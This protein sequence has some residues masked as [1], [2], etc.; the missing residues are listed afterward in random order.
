VTLE[1]E[2]FTLQN[3]AGRDPLAALAKIPSTAL[4]VDPPVRSAEASDRDLDPATRALVHSVR[5]GILPDEGMV[6]FERV[7]DGQTPSVV[8]VSPVELGALSD[9]ASQLTAS[10]PTLGIEFE[11]PAL[12]NEYIEPT[13]DDERTMVEFWKQLLGISAVGVRDSFFDLGGHSLIA[14]RLFSM[15][16]SAWGV[17]L[18]VGTLLEAPTVV[19]LIERVVAARDH[20]TA[21]TMPSAHDAASPF[22]GGWSSL[23]TMRKSGSR[24][25]IFCVAGKGGNPMNLRHLAARLGEDQPFYG[26]QHRGVDGVLP[27]HESIESMALACIADVRQVQPR[28]PYVLGGFSAG[29]LVAFEMARS[30]RNAGED[31][32]LLFMLDTWDPAYV[33][34]QQK[35]RLATHLKLLKLRGPMYLLEKCAELQRRAVRRVARRWQGGVSSGDSPSDQF[36]ELTPQQATVQAWTQMEQRY[37][38]RPDASSGVLYRPYRSAVDAD[39][40]SLRAGNQYNG[41]DQFLLGGVE[42]VELPGGHST[43]CEEPH[44]RILAKRLSAAIDRALASARRTPSP[45]TSVDEPFTSMSPSLGR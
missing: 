15:I 34:R 38:A 14:A 1:V 13:S 39:W 29:G 19:Q 35:S 44:V 36:R 37:V 11:R 2:D 43:M 31:I 8:I 33:H 23:V 3:M 42:V 7:I 32:A 6:A 22:F 21:T 28:G 20:G 18:P 30:L 27:P 5:Q 9:L 25:P 10:K 41:W 16:K 45:L 40:I 12:N 24:P 4:E 17:S 26:I